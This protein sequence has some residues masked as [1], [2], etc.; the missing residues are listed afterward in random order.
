[1]RAA[2]QKTRRPG[3]V[4]I[5]TKFSR[6]PSRPEFVERRGLLERLDKAVEQHRMILV[7]APPGFGKTTLVTQWLAR[8]AVPTA[9]LA[10]DKSDSDPERFLRYLVAAIEASTP[11][12]LPKST[13]LLDARMQ[14]VFEQFKGQFGKDLVERILNTN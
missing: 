11:H 4:L 2:N 10:L 8:Q 12:R 13:A 1:M 14:P 3:P 6:P 7:S 5:R 9:W